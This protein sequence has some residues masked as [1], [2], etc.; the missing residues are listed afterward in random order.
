MTHSSQDRNRRILVIDDNRAIHDDFR[1]ILN[2]TTTE[3][4]ALAQAETVLFGEEAQTQGPARF[5]IDSAHQ[6]QEGLARVQLSIKAKCPYAMAFV[7]IRMPRL[8]WGGNHAETLGGRSR[9]SSGHL[10]RLFRLLV[11]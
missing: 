9:P 4:V 7:D 3:N 8:G 2:G 11:G 10:H 6:G 1:K 5:Q